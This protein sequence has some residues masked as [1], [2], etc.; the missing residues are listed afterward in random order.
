MAKVVTEFDVQLAK[1]K[2]KT[3]Q[4]R[5]DMKQMAAAAGRAKI[6]DHLFGG[7]GAS[8]KGVLGALG[9][10]GGLAALVKGQMGQADDLAD[11]SLKLGEAPEVLQR[12]GAAAEISGASVESLT[13]A[14]LPLEKNLGEEDGDKA[15]AALA[16]YGLEAGRL[17]ALPLDEKILA[18]S[19]AFQ[20]ARQDGT[21]LADLQA[22]LGRGSTELIPL[23]GQTATEIS[24]LFDAVHV[25]SNDAIFQLA[26][27]N[28]QF[29]MIATNATNGLKRFIAVAVDSAR[30][31]G[32]E[33]RE[34]MMGEAGA[35][36]AAFAAQ[37]K[38]MADGIAKAEQTLTQRKERAAALSAAMVASREKAAAARLADERD[39]RDGRIAF[40]RRQIDDKRM[41]GLPPAE[42]LEAIARELRSILAAASP[43]DPTLTGLDN[44]IAGAD[45]VTKEI[46]LQNKLRALDLMRQADEVARPAPSR[47]EAA[48]LS[49]AVAAGVNS[50]MGRSAHEVIPL[51]RSSEQAMQQQTD[52][53]RRLDDRL[54]EIRDSLRGGERSGWDD[55]V[56]TF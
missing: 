33:F 11:L 56:F 22:L 9:L 4:I 45:P 13:D 8:F 25:V 28:D 20:K 50:L 27:L 24:G 7:F 29:D 6:G 51:S 41:A 35:V 19:A 1:W 55:D 16:R 30:I 37:Q 42:K 15:A 2:A 18:L 52:L 34:A 26:A 38:R 5:A 3:E 39:A 14:M 47:Q 43:R 12:V 36:S 21:G 53:L 10:G 31:W 40:L 54:R 17:M 32:A 49:G 48:G 46:L 23:L 44:Q